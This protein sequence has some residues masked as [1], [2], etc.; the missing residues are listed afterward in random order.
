MAKNYYK[1]TAADIIRRLPLHRQLNASQTLLVKL[2]PTW[3]NWA[4]RH[5]M[6]SHPIDQSTCDDF[7]SDNNFSDTQLISADRGKLIVACANSACASRIK[8]LQQ[9]LLDALRSQGFSEIEQI[10]VRIQHTLSN[11]VNHID[12]NVEKAQPAT[13]AI[14]RNS[15]TS[16]NSLK[17][18]E[19][20]QRMVVNEQL[21][22]SLKNLFNTLKSSN[23]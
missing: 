2:T 4:S 1:Q 19:Q 21:A 18:I 9:N 14:T 17:A 20:C 11:K 6:Q 7:N 16:S 13:T 15:T 3:Q 23:N 12:K 22:N 8:H 5:L 10:I